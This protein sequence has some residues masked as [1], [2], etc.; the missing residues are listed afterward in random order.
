MSKS[1]ACQKCHRITE[2]DICPVCKDSELTKS[3]KGFTIITNP[4]KSEIAD[5]LDAKSPGKYALRLKK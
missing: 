4:E 2:G 5:K 1:K 3:W